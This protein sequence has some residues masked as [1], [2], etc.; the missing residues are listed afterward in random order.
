MS[1]VE[2]VHLEF[3]LGLRDSRDDAGLI[4]ALACRNFDRLSALERDGLHLT[5]GVVHALQRE[6][7]ATVNL[8]AASR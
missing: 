6:R 4:R 2:S 1:K 8:G 3:A 5:G 7:I